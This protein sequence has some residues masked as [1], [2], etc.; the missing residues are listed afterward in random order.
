MGR[1]LPS[2]RWRFAGMFD[3]EEFEN[4]SRFS[5]NRKLAA[6]LHFRFGRH[7]C[8]GK[9]IADIVMVEIMRSLLLLPNLR[10]APGSRGKICHDGPVATLLCVASTR[11]RRG[12]RYTGRNATVKRGL[13]G[14]HYAYS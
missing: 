7:V 1:A 14:R 10:R 3:P 9:D 2:L 8:F 4:P 11:I 12:G 13:R 5:S 6:Y